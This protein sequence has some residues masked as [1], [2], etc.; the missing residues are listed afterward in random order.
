MRPG[1]KVDADFYRKVNQQLNAKDRQI[2]ALQQRVEE[3]QARAVADIPEL[4]PELIALEHDLVAGA[5][6]AAEA[7]SPSHPAHEEA[8]ALAAASAA[9]PLPEPTLSSALSTTL[10]ER[11]QRRI[12]ALRPHLPDPGADDAEVVIA[13]LKLLE[14]FLRRQSEGCR[15][16]VTDA[17]GGITDVDLLL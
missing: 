5:A 7:E 4:S 13:G 11:L 17:G 8:L 10:A 6:A 15:V 9:A 1:S 2:R 16:Q 3:L 12:A 14:W